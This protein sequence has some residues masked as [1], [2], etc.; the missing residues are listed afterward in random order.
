VAIDV[1][2]V[3]ARTA[4][5]DEFVNC[6]PWAMVPMMA[7]GYAVWQPVLQWALHLTANRALPFHTIAQWRLFIAAMLVIGA[8]EGVVL[9]YA[10]RHKPSV[11]RQ[12]LDLQV[13]FAASAPLTAAREFENI[14]VVLSI[15][16]II[17]VT[18][19]LATLFAYPVSWVKRAFA[20]AQGRAP[21]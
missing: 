17:V 6:H 8:I 7:I 9:V 14:S 10:R 2:A 20:V 4:R 18:V 13:F 1:S 3:N 16:N 15:A 12:W 21:S 19:L 11:W 5:F